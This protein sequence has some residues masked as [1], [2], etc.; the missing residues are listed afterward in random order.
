M[1]RPKKEEKEKPKETAT[2]LE[3]FDDIIGLKRVKELLDSYVG[4][5]IKRKDLFQ[6][7]GKERTLA[8]I[9]TG[10]PG[11]GKTA[12]IRAT[13]GQFRLPVLMANAASL[14]SSY[15]GESQKNIVELFDKA[16]R[17]APCILFIDEFDSLG[18]KKDTPQTDGSSKVFQDIV[19]EILIQMSGIE[20][21][22][23]DIFI[24]AATNRPYAIDPSLKRGGRFENILYVPLP[25]YMDRI[26]MF[27]Y[28][29][30]KD[31]GDKKIV[32]VCYER[33]SRATMGYSGADI[34]K[35]CESAKLKAITKEHTSNRPVRI[36]SW[37]IL[38]LLMDKE[39]GKSSV[40]DWY[41]TIE[42]NITTKMSDKDQQNYSMLIDDIKRRNKYRIAIKFIRLMSVY[43]T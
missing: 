10:A 34:K 25:N 21:R 7:Y 9:L 2:Y 19:N 31:I 22:G 33:L 14:V 13:S 8:L 27:R 32:D 35:L 15:V 36:H 11:T 5:A 1:P 3:T 43:L 6:K 16:R 29:L 38:R 12:V 20:K 39:L 18:Y 26:A 30:N 42:Q 28:Y 17:N 40:D 24:I 4:L 37:T 41:A 23:E